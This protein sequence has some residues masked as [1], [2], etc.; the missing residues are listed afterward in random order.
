M[1]IATALTL[2]VLTVD[3]L[4]RLVP[5]QF[6]MVLWFFSLLCSLAISAFIIA[7]TIRF[8][9]RVLHVGIAAIVAVGAYAW[10]EGRSPGAGGSLHATLFH[11]AA[12]LTPIVLCCTVALTSANPPEPQGG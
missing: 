9:P 1:I 4:D 7:R 6:D 8:R 3:I 12:I 2:W 5:R 10:L 11:A